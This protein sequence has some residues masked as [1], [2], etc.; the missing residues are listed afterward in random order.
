MREDYYGVFDLLLM[1]WDIQDGRIWCL[2]SESPVFEQWLK[3]TI[4]ESMYMHDLTYRQAYIHALSEQGY[5]QTEISEHLGILR[6]S[7]S[8]TMRII[9]LKIEDWGDWYEY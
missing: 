5:T 9:R 3:P 6:S 4:A 1:D 8:K 7:V 2:C